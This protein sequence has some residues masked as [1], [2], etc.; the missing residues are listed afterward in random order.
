[1]E[2]DTEVKSNESP[3]VLDEVNEENVSGKVEKL[4]EATYWCTL[5]KQ[6]GSLEIF[7]LPDF[8]EVFLFPH[9]DLSPAFWKEIKGAIFNCAY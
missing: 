4:E 6:D 9:F 2:I 5:F 1:M 3:R 8:D 7:K